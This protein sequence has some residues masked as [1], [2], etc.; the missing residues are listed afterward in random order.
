MFDSLDSSLAKHARIVRLVPYT[1]PY[2]V[3]G[4][5]GIALP[6]HWTAEGLPLGIQLVAKQGAEDLLIRVASQL[7]AA[8]PWIDRRPP[9]CA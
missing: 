9:V 2:N 4:Q 1:S 7:E 5:P 3:S 8:S 6:L